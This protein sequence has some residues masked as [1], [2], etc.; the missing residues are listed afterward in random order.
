MSEIPS[1]F[2][3]K[4]TFRSLPQLAFWTWLIVFI[5]DAVVLQRFHYSYARVA[6]V[7][8]IGL[9]VSCLFEFARY[10][11]LNPVEKEGYGNR[12]LLVLNAF[13]IFMYASSYT[14]LTKQIG[15]WGEAQSTVTAE[16]KG[17]IESG[18]LLEAVEW[19]IPVFAK[20][21]SYFPDVTA[22]AESERLQSENKALRDSLNNKQEP[23]S[24]GVDA[25][26]QL[27]SGLNQR[28]KK[29]NYDLAN[30]KRKK[31]ESGDSALFR[32]NERLT[33]EINNLNN[34]VTKLKLENT[35]LNSKVNQLTDNTKRPKLSDNGSNFYQQRYFELLN[36]VNGFN[37]HQAKWI[38]LGSSRTGKVKEY[39]NRLMLASDPNETDFYDF[40][41]N[42]PISTASG[43][44]DVKA[45]Q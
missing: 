32:E 26:N 35:N 37:N 45:P 41:F 8:I 14:G 7:W 27:I 33:N 29:L 31:N 13:L 43:I 9:I 10:R 38:A 40:L 34:E 39:V 4:K 20:Q 1:D 36:R 28:I 17:V 11:N 18:I 42:T 19:S 22:L 21:T 2:I 23:G 24:I 25:Y 16:N 30:C 15:A 6:A 12:F 3:S 5:I 44:K